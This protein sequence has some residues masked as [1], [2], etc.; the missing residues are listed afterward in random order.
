M[1]LPLAGAV[2]I[3]SW[4]TF[5]NARSTASVVQDRLLLGSA[6]IVAEPLRFEDGGFQHPIAPAA[7]ALFQSSQI[8]RIYYRVTTGSG[9]LLVGYEDLEALAAPLQPEQPH[10]F[11]TLV[12]G[13]PERAVAFLQPVVGAPDGL[14]V[15]AQIGQT[16]N[17]HAQLT[18]AL[19][20]HSMGPQLF[21]LVLTAG[22]IALGL[23]QGLQPLIRLR[24]RVLLRQAGTLQPLTLDGA[25]AE[26]RPLVAAIND[27]I[28]R[29]ALPLPHKC[30]FE[31]HCLSE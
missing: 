23:R 26:L 15:L 6:R 1:L 2:A 7:L 16:M 24:D 27:Y 21:I 25:P 20:A 17:G 8:D 12:R 9:R 18:R 22:L 28:A 30:Q 19:W 3:D 14:P 31:C 4:I 10:Y 13:E 29:L 11:N 5:D